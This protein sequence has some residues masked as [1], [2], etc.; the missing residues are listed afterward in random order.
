MINTER[1]IYEI[2]KILNDKINRLTILM[3]IFGCLFAYGLYNNHKAIEKCERKVD[4]RYFNTTRS[5]EDI[6]NIKI[7]T[8]DGLIIRQI[9]TNQ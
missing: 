6:Y 4:F 2:K 5:L 8:K 3:L 9:A 7:S 1:A